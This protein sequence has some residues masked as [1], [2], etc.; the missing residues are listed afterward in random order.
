LVGGAI[1]QT[2]GAKEG[3]AQHIGERKMLL[4]LDNFEQVIEA[5]SELSGLVQACPNLALM[6]TSRELLRVA[7]EVECAVPPLAER[8]AVELFCVRSRL[9]PPDAMSWQCL[10]LFDTVPCVEHTSG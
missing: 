6:I 8:D 5:A 7:G 2:L 9:A 4:L 10:R 3:P 1:A